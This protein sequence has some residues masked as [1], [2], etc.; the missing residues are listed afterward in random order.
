[1]KTKGTPF[2]FV[3]LG[4]VFSTA[5]LSGEGRYLLH[6]SGPSVSKHFGPYHDRFN[7]FHLGLGVEAYCKK[8]RWL[9]GGNGH[10]MFNDSNGRTSYW[11]GIAPGYFIG[12]QKK[13]WGSLAIIVGGLKK[14]EYNEGRFSLFGLPYLTVGYNRIGLNI[15]YIPRIVHVTYPIL[16]LQ[17]KILIYPFQ[18][19]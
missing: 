16:L 4:L 14:A 7:D 11:V 3:L 8:G 18:H 1:M 19:K 9:F 13:I 15:G 10:F 2:F 12:D 5:G 6:L 17:L